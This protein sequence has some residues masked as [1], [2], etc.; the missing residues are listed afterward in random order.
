MSLLE[1]KIKKNKDFLDG[2]EPGEGHLERFQLKLA[3]LHREEAP[4]KQSPGRPQ[5]IRVAA[6]IAVL[7]TLS[8]VAYLISPAWKNNNLQANELPQEILEAKFYYNNLTSEKLAQ[9]ENCALSPEDAMQIK[10]MAVKELDQ[11]D[12]NSTQLENTL[13][14]NKDNPK[15]KNA[16]LNNY[17]TKSKL[18]D[19]I[20]NR[21]CKI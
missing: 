14:Q 17:R 6:V 15:V 1:E 3:S 21:L 10:D 20:I 5:F 4:V 13:L 16:L 9:I 7:A 18:V 8:I 19:D 11:L 2:A 12:A